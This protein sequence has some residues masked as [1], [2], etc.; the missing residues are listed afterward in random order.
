[1]RGVNK[2]IIMGSLGNDPDVRYMTNGNA[3]CNFSVATNEVWKDK[4]GEQ[5]EK[6]EWHRI[7]AFGKLAEI[8]GEYLKKGSGVYLEGKIQTRKWTDKNGK[9]NYTTEIVASE[10]QFLSGGGQASSGGSGNRASASQSGGR[11]APDYSG[12]PGF[13]SGADSDDIPF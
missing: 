13:M 5:Q 3:A 11:E 12:G 10:V 8:I 1:M 7:V 9:D 2:A 4:Q 6:T